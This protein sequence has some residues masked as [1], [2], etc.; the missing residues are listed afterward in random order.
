MVD[1]FALLGEPRRPWLDPERIKE[2]FH[3]LSRERHPDQAGGAQDAFADLNLAQETLRDP[4]LRLRHLL[5]LEHPAI[6]PS[7]PATVPATLADDFAP[8][9]ELLQRID[10]YL[11]RKAAASGAL[12]RALLA[13]EE[14]ALRIGARDRLA[15]LDAKIASAL[16]DLRS[17]DAGWE[18]NHHATAARLLD[19]YG[20]FAYLS[21]WAGQLRERLFHLES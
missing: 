9:H 12:A 20:R 5:E 14:T 4:K 15:G 19:L 11:P 13:R 3:R 1:Y 18:P 21:R 17:L 8:I 2:T 6:R 16:T 7:G 10:A